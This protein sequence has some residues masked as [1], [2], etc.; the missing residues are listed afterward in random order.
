MLSTVFKIFRHPVKSLT[1]ELLNSV[2]LSAGRAVP[3]D[4]RFALALGS[5]P[6]TGSVS[7]WMPKTRF[8]ALMNSRKLAA[9]DTRF[10]DE[11]E[12]LSIFRGGK[13]VA[14]GCLT[15]NIGRATIEE[16]FAAYMGEEAAGKP[17]LVESAPEHVLSDHVNP[18][19]S[20]LNL[21][22]VKDL[23]RVI[24]EPV[25]PL[26]FRANVWIE[27]LKPWQEFEWIGA[28]LMIGDAQI[29]VTERIDRCAATNV[30]PATAERDM[31]IPKA[32]KRAFGHV[33]MGV[34]AR[35]LRTGSVNAGDKI[36]V[37]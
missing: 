29:E 27:G 25:D 30:N 8:L 12:T 19:I 36:T 13:K 1:P 4:R 16:F 34:F 20:L 6:I 2:T 7:E 9:L 33:D 10:N 14:H 5:T 21:A 35:V 22:S 3:N 28:E 37:S 18:S 23:E 17:R 32:L 15:N 24:K 11:T 31:N 26:R